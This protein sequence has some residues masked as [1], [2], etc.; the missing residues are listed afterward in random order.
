M[1]VD[2]VETR[3]TDDVQVRGRNHLLDWIADGT[4]TLSSFI[5]RWNTIVRNFDF[6]NCDLRPDHG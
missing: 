2:K 4:V 6:F 3:M 5:A 1:G